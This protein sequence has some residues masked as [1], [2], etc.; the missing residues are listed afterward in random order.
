MFSLEQL[1]VLAEVEIPLAERGRRVVL[2][3]TPAAQRAVRLLESAG[4]HASSQL[5]G[6][7]SQLQPVD[8]QSELAG[9]GAVFHE[10]GPSPVGKHEA[11]E[12]AAERQVGIVLKG[13][14]VEPLELRGPQRSGRSAPSR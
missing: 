10:R 11:E 13:L 2:G 14:L 8:P 5:V 6:V 12:L 1:D 9:P 7:G 3:Q 4:V